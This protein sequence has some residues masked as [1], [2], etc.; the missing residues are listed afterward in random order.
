MTRRLRGDAEVRTCVVGAF[1]RPGGDRAGASRFGARRDLSVGAGGRPA[2]A[3]L[4][5]RCPLAGGLPDRRL[6]GRTALGGAMCSPS[7]AWRP[8]AWPARLG[9]RRRRP[10]SWRSPASPRAPCAPVAWPRLRRAARSVY[11]PRSRRHGLAFGRRRCRM[12]QPSVGARSRAHSPSARTPSSSRHCV[13]DHGWATRFGFTFSQSRARLAAVASVPA[14]VAA[15]AVR[16]G[17]ARRSA[18]SSRGSSPGP[19]PVR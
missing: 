16:A 19:R 10:W 18:G 5:R 8:A 17:C 1:D 9:L 14:D 6:R 7:G 2:R 11:R 12:R 3:R 4:A 15:S 13:V